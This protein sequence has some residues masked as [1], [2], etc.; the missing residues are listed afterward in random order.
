MVARMRFLLFS[1]AL[2]L[3]AC[4]TAGPP[5]SPAS[6]SA[7]AESSALNSTRQAQMLRAAGGAD[8]PT[9]AE[10][11]RA[12]GSADIARQ[13]G[14]GAALTYRLET[15]ALLLLFSADTSNALRLAE[16]HASARRNGQAAPSL[17]RCAAEASAR[18]S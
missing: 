16:V 3:A 6:S 7:G 17:D 18:R 13:E 12:F 10:I 8:A 9:R 4:A 1:A 5:T 11:E 14:A 15:C 2:L